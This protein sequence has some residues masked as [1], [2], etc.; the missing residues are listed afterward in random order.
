MVKKRLTIEEG[1][2]LIK[3]KLNIDRLGTRSIRIILEECLPFSLNI[4]C[5]ENKLNPSILMD[6][7]EKSIRKSKQC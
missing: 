1:R 5:K 6:K 2:K 7:H 4:Y 3:D